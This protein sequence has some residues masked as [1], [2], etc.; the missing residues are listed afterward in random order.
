MGDRGPVSKRSDQRRRTNDDGIPVDHAEGAEVV[1]VPAADPAWHPVAVQWFESLAKSGQSTFYEPSDWG[2]AVM[3]AEAMS[4]E[5][6]DQPIVVGKGK[7]ATVEMH[8][9]PMTG[10]ALSAILRGMTSL[11]VTEG[12]RR[13][14][15]LE[16]LRPKPDGEEGGNADVTWLDD[17]R[18]R[19]TG[20]G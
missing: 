11:M 2:T 14:V 6:S 3:L 17:A 13:R 16:L 9:V 19:A 4:R 20:A 7:D 1:E 10:A 5:L 18:R 15:R 8:K 12:D